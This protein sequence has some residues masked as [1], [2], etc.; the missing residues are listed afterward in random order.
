MEHKNNIQVLHTQEI[1]KKYSRIERNIKR[2]LTE[3]FLLNNIGHKDNICR[4]FS[5]TKDFK[6]RELTAQENSKYLSNPSTIKSFTLKNTSKDIKESLIS[7]IKWNVIEDE[8]AQRYIEWIEDFFDRFHKE[9]MRELAEGG[10]K[11]ANYLRYLKQSREVKNIKKQNVKIEVAKIL[12]DKF[13]DEAFEE[14]VNYKKSTESRVILSKKSLDYLY[15]LFFNTNKVRESRWKRMDQVFHDWDFSFITNNEKWTESDYIDVMVYLIDKSKI[16]YYWKRGIKWQKEWSRK[17]SQYADVLRALTNDQLGISKMNLWEQNPDF[18]RDDTTKRLYMIWW[19]LLEN[20]VVTRNQDVPWKKMQLNRRLKSLPSCVEKVIEGKKIN[21]TIGF[22]LSTLWI[23]DQNFDE[24]KAITKTRFK[25]FKASLAEFPEK[26]VKKWQTIRIKSVTIDNKWVLEPEQLD[27]MVSE[28]SKIIPVSKRIISP[29]PYISPDQWEEKMEK[30]YPEIVKDSW[31]WEILKSFYDKISRWKNR[32]RN[33]WY[34]D[35]KFN[36]VFEVDNEQWNPI[37][38]RMM[39]V[40]F[41]DINNGEWLS[42]YNIRNFERWVNTQSRLSFSVPLSEVR[43]SCE[44]NLKLMQLRAKKWNQE[45]WKTSKKNF[46]DIVFDDWSVI[47][48]SSFSRRNNANSKALDIAIVKIINYF[49]QK[50]TFV[51]CEGWDDEAKNFKLKNKL[52]TVQDLH[53]F[54]VMKNLHICSS[55]E[56]AA[57]QHSYLQQWWDRKVWIYLSDIDEI[58]RI[59]LGEL[60]DP[61]NLWK[62]RDPK[63]SADL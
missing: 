11:S 35:F 4:G 55:L 43:K 22:R 10:R 45:V 50:G 56:L 63:Y 46:F 39:E 24:I 59:S 51:L 58:G 27:D 25:M 5:I 2:C 54:D 33:W 40:Q 28:L 44:K 17:T 1:K 38:E 49:L 61:M 15:V 31:K 52:L 13:G 8:I 20:I 18:Q 12:F 3:L 41:D 30:H 32:G 62:K 21:D 42:N 26:Y 14:A 19:W 48:I 53:D 6:I 47:N 29:S 16:N 37:G 57:Q 7:L 36:I 60:I 23:S 9:N 34:K